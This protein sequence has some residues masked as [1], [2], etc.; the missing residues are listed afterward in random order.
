M[1]LDH[2][3]EDH[4]ITPILPVKLVNRTDHTCPL[5]GSCSFPTRR[6]TRS[7]P[8]AAILPIETKAPG[9]LLNPENGLLF[10]PGPNCLLRQIRG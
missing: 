4:V 8:Y 1:N 7:I 5:N 10:D 2:L 3:T 6:G 9:I